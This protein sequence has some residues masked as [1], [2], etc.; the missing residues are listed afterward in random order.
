M[1]RVNFEE[2]VS[3][4]VEL[5]R[6]KKTTASITNKKTFPALLQPGLLNFGPY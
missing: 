1:F 6:A 5:N 4:Y 2:S 3:F